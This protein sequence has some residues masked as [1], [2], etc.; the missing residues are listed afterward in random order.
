MDFAP[1]NRTEDLRGTLLG[2][3]NDRVYPAERGLRDAKLHRHE[4]IEDLKAEAR[5]LGLW[6]LFLPDTRFGAGLSNCEYAP[7]AELSGWSPALAPEAMNCSAPDTGNM[8]ILAAFGSAEQQERWLEP[9][10]EGTIRSCFAMTEPGVASSDATNIA[11]RIERD[12]DEYIVTG[13]KWFTTG[14]AS[15]RC[16]VAIFMG[17]TNPDADPYHRQSMVLVPMDAPGVRV[18]R[19]VPV[20]GYDDEE[21]GGHPETEFDHVR[22]PTTNLLGDDGGGFTIAQARL[23]PGRVH[24]CM[25]A[26]GMAE[27]ALAAMCRR[28]LDRR[29]F[30]G[31]LADQGV[32]QEWIA[33]SRIRIEAARLLVLKTAWLMDTAGNRAARVE[34]SAIKALVPE[35]AT[36]VI[37]RAIQAHGG[38]GVSDDTPLASFYAAARTLHLADGPDEVH[39]M[40][41]ARRELRSHAAAAAPWD[42]GGA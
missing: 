24:H 29:A 36:W 4:V 1:S 8:E 3:M 26:I 34:I 15:P 25:R 5:R 19:R 39:R 13:R 42:V 6:N 7:L 9:L 16:R 17:V 22:V 30:G 32:I 11:S 23:G 35:V 21:E 38:A 28:V 37:D 14:A 2:F 33:E 10:L 41:I 18:V 20:F 40:A 27:R 12:G 31:P